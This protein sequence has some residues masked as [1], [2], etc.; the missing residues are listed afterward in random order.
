MN[1]PR[2]ATD[3]QANM[4][5]SFNP[6]TLPHSAGMQ[7]PPFES[8]HWGSLGEGNTDPLGWEASVL[9]AHYDSVRRGFTTGLLPRRPVVLNR[10]ARRAMRTHQRRY[11]GIA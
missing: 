4:L 3:H 2:I 10:R 8:R 5:G 9:A 7:Q 1:T 6:E 11:G